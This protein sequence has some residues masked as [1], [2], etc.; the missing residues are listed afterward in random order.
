MN[1]HPFFS[2]VVPTYNRSAILLNTLQTILKQTYND[3]E[4][5]VVD[6]GSTDNTTEIIQPVLLNE[7]RVKLFKQINKERG[8]AR[9]FGFSKSNGTY[10]IFF[11]SDDLMHENHLLVLLKNIKEQNF[12]LF[13]STKF[14]FINEK[15][16]HFPSDICRLQQGNYNYKLFLNGN[17]LAC[18]V[19]I[20][21]ANP[22]L[23]L[24]EEDRRYAVKEDWLFMLHNLQ[25]HQLFLIDNITISMYDH[26]DRSMR[27]NNKDIIQRTQYALKWILEKI[28]LTDSDIKELKAHVNYFC[29]IHSYLDN[30][31]KESIG[32]SVKAIQL[33]G[34][35]IKY[36][37]LLFK[38]IIG[39]K[40][41]SL[42]K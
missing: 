37:S 30:N 34:V 7:K 19:C 41:V 33:G 22:D 24:F 4:I 20:K 8:A 5:I 3:F 26:P 32:Y 18:N 15:G 40:T 12:P 17:P 38:S 6:D 11:D 31:K 16:N 13:I 27:S 21:K 2:I 10:V 25:K 23:F 9:N 14:D 39:K 42:L 29:G 1:E 35:K 36:L 28:N